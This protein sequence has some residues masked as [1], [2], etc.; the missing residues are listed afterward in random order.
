MEAIVRSQLRVCIPTFLLLVSALAASGAPKDCYLAFDG[1]DDFLLP[2]GNLTFSNEFTIEVWYR[3]STQEDQGTYGDGI[4]DPLVNRYEG[5]GARGT[6]LILDSGNALYFASG[7]WHTE[8]AISP[9]GQNDGEWHHVAAVRMPDTLAMY[10]D[11]DLVSAVPHSDY[12]PNASGRLLIG[13]GDG[14]IPGWWEGDLDDLRIWSGVRSETEINNHM[15]VELLGHEAGLQAYWKFNDGDGQTA[16][17]A[18]GNGF[19]ATL[20]DS[21]D[22]DAA[23]PTWVCPPVSVRASGWASVKGKYR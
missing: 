1:T 9:G 20:G 12:D 19:D 6:F 10:I 3:S 18:T 17:D 23:D 5:G 11:G 8:Y 16:S 14:V 13:R 15:N 2:A 4:S 7:E 22:P 21:A